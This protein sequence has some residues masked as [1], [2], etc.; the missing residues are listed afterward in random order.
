MT[1]A[2]GRST[3]FTGRR[4]G[5]ALLATTMLTGATQAWAQSSATNVDEL[6][7][8]AQKREENL[9]N[10]ALSIQAIGTVKLEQLQVAPPDALIVLSSE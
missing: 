6:V 8:T 7:V 5:A 3:G 1:R 2:S 9:Q 10:V 4:L